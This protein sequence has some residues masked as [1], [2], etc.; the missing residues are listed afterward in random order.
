MKSFLFKCS[1]AEP[2]RHRR[3]SGSS[4]AL[5]NVVEKASAKTQKIDRGF[6]VNRK[7]R[8][9]CTP[10]ARRPHIWY[11]VNMPMKLVR[12]LAQGAIFFD[13][14]GQ[15]LRFLPPD[16]VWVH[17]VDDGK[18]QLTSQDVANV[19][20]I[21]NLPRRHPI[22]AGES[23]IPIVADVFGRPVNYLKEEWQTLK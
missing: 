1:M 22:Q 15:L 3:P 10:I 7:W 12:C 17:F 18:S 11:H 20:E 6:G 23:P 19:R 13:F 2:S 4:E 21:M 8:T 9:F 16:G 5:E 14:Q